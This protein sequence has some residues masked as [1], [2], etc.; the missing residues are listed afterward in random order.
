MPV[1]EIKQRFSHRPNVQHSESSVH[2]IWSRTVTRCFEIVD[3]NGA[4]TRK[5]ARRQLAQ[6]QLS[7][8]L[9][10]IVC[11][12]NRLFVARDRAGN[13]NCGSC[14]CY[15]L[16][17]SNFGIE[18]KKDSAHTTLTD[19]RN[20]DDGVQLVTDFRKELHQHFGVVRL[21]LDQ[22]DQ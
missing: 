21:H 4:T 16:S 3:Q 8:M 7:M 5:E 14:F 17:P 13:V 15:M 11:H 12:H 2:I 10:R 9:G 1:R 18:N 22:L 19:W 6:L 20:V